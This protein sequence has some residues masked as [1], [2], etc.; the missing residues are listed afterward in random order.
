MNLVNDNVRVFCSWSWRVARYIR[1]VSG[2]V[3]Y[4]MLNIKGL[5][6]DGD[7]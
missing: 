1:E 6:V 3:Q 4:S 7:R 5:M 2:G